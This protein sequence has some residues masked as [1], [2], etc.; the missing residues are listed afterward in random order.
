ME[1][2]ARHVANLPELG[3][4]RDYLGVVEKRRGIDARKALEA[5]I[6]I[7]WSKLNK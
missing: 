6:K 5:A 2:E 7:E 1:C 4:R 3:L